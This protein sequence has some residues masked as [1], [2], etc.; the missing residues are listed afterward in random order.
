MIRA[1]PLPSFAQETLGSRM[2]GVNANSQAPLAQSLANYRS[3]LNKFVISG[4]LTRSRRKMRM[5]RYRN[6]SREETSMQKMLGLLIENQV[7]LF[8]Q[9]K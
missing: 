8:E 1:K 5:I 4:D 3:T 7:R 2:A 9:Q 6:R